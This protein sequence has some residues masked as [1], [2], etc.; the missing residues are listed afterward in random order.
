MSD[1]VVTARMGK[2]GVKGGC[3]EREEDGRFEVHAAHAALVEANFA[4]AVV[5]KELGLG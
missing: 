1:R 5:E 4:G 3:G 2:G